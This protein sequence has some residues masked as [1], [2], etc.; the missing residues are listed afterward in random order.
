MMK[1]FDLMPVRGSSDVGT[2]GTS[3]ESMDSATR[4][5][6][7]FDWGLEFFVKLFEADEDANFSSTLWLVI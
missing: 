5:P 6:L 3:I 7:Q 2:I 1:S 4:I